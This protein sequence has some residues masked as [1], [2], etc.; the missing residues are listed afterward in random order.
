MKFRL[1]FLLICLLSVGQFA[2][3]SAQNKR[4]ER[5][6]ERAE[7]RANNKVDGKINQ[8]VDGAVDD[9]FNAIGG[10]FKKKKKDQDAGADD[11]QSTEEADANAALGNLFGGGGDWEPYTNPRNFS[12]SWNIVTT[13]RNGKTETMNMDV[14]VTEDKSAV[15]IINPDN[16]KENTRMILNTQTGKTT[17]VSTDNKGETSAMRMR[18]PNMQA[19]IE[20]EM[21]KQEQR[22][23]DGQS[24]RW[25]INN[26]G[27]RM[28]IDGYDC[29]KIIVTDTETGDVTTSWVT[30]DTGLNQMQLTRGMAAS[31]G[32]GQMSMPADAPM[33]D[34]ILI[35]ATTV[36]DKETT[37]IHVTN[38][39]VDEATDRSIMNLE[40]IEVTEVGF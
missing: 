10:L 22:G 37:E 15:N 31:F 1:L 23:E 34:G 26:T 27:E 35:K 13:K 2:D 38:I 7:N 18:M 17:L 4:T 40:G 25:T 24:E 29:Q 36:T 20:K 3:L 6:K 9:A 19:A 5:A 12:L 11:A 8:K 30:D 33:V 16:P 21:A 14:A 39:K 32:G 28:N